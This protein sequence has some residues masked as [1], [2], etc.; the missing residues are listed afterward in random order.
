MEARSP[1]RFLLLTGALALVVALALVLTTRQEVGRATSGTNPYET[2]AATD[3]NPDPNIVETTIVADEATVDIGT[4]VHGA[5]RADLQR[6]DP[7]ARRSASRSATRSSS[8]SRTSSRTRAAIHWHGI[9]LAERDGRHAVHAEPGPAGR[10]R[11]ST[12]S[13]STGPGIFW[14]HPHHHSSTNQ[15]F[16]GLYGMIVVED[17]NEAAL[18]R[19][20]RHPAGAP[21]ACRSSSA[22]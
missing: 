4:G 9:E 17:P 2:V 6:H 18:H 3:T 12:S 16:K 15:V 11:S 10:R 14:Y 13:R 22:T 1:R 8:T 5:T 19:R 21:D 20:R 7:R